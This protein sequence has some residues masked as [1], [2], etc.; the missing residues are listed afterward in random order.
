VKTTIKKVLEDFL[1]ESEY[2]PDEAPQ[3]TEDL[4]RI[5]REEIKSKSFPKNNSQF[6]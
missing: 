4:V 2:D 6:N 1:G 5:L 3:Q